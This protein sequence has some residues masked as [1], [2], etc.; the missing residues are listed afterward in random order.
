MSKAPKLT[1]R[2]LCL[3]AAMFQLASCGIDP[4]V[5]PDGAVTTLHI[6]AGMTEVDIPVQKDTSVIP[7]DHVDVL[8]MD[9]GQEITVLQNVEVLLYFRSDSRVYIL[10]T[11]DDAQ[12]VMHAEIRSPFQLRRL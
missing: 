3:V 6:P 9:K 2:T 11:P 1:A 5:Q 8:M 4:D 12:T 10:V 7:G